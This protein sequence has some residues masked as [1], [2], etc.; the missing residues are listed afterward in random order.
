MLRHTRRTGTA[1]A[2]AALLA[3]TGAA[4]ADAATPAQTATAKDVTS[5]PFT[6]TF[7][8]QRAAEA[9]ENAA[10]GT[11]DAVGRLGTLPLMDLH[12][13]I[14]CLN[15]RGN[16]MG[17]FYP[18]AQSNPALFSQI[19]M[20]VLIYMSVDGKGHATAI[21]FLPVPFTKVKSCAPTAGTLL[22]AT[23]AASLTS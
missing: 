23:G 2:A 3:L 12:G 20:G 8:A 4:A 6:F 14:T 17:L 21:E 15:V 11:F 1:F 13:P 5:G 16:R 19:M 10:T 9:K 22:P 18:V 7:T